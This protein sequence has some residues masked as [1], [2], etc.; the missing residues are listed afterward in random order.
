MSDKNTREKDSKR[1]EQ[2]EEEIAKADDEIRRRQ[3]SVSEKR[4]EA[5]RIRARLKYSERK[6]QAAE[7]Q[8]RCESQQ[9]EIERLR[10]EISAL[11]NSAS[12]QNRGN[13]GGSAGAEITAGKTLTEG[14]KT[15]EMLAAR[16]AA[17][18]R[19]E[20]AIKVDMRDPYSQ[21]SDDAVGPLF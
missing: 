1:L 17:A 20:N 19:N 4:A 15:I 10:E 18:K 16:T 12:V 14:Q 21:E 11:K 9:A 2:L 7:L 8:G 6:N 3:E 5:R 13:G